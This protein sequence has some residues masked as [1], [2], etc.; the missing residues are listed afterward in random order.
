MLSYDCS[1]PVI[2][3]QL[4]I[5][6][7]NPNLIQEAVPAGLSQAS[8]LPTQEENDS[9]GGDWDGEWNHLLEDFFEDEDYDHTRNISL[10]REW[11]ESTEAIGNFFL[12]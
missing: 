1:K 2:A 9:Y 8:H 5:H 7:K 6:R 3:L 10:I 11:N 4:M 12:T